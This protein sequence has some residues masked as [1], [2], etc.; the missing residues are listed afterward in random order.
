MRVYHAVVVNE[1]GRL[2]DTVEEIEGIL[3]A[4]KARVARR[5]P[6]SSGIA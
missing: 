1:E 5:L 6:T 3:R 4:E 2:E